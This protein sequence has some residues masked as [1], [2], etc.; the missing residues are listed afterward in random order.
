MTSFWLL[1]GSQ[2][3]SKLAASRVLEGPALAEGWMEAVNGGAG[4]YRSSYQQELR[5]QSLMPA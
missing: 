2:E 5:R 1:T 4:H 3:R